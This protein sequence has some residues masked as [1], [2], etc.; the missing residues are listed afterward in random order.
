MS[1]PHA[2]T[3]CS[4]RIP[5]SRFPDCCTPSPAS[6]TYI[7]YHSCTLS[8]GYFW[9]ARGL[10]HYLPISCNTCT[11]SGSFP[12]FLS[13]LFLFC[14]WTCC[15]GCF[16]FCPGVRGDGM[17]TGMAMVNVAWEY[18]TDLFYLHP[19]AFT[20]LNLCQTPTPS[21]TAVIVFL[22]VDSQIVAHP[23]RPPSL[24]FFIIVAL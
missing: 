13:S 21:L 2:V 11:P 22:V 6:I 3:H 4:H 19:F 18:F 24:I 20:S 14:C 15:G 23:L 1:N 7:F 17:W 12:F 5:C 16:S 9:G 10:S 8:V